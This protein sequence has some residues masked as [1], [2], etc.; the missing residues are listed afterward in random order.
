MFNHRLVFSSYLPEWTGVIHGLDVPFVFGALV[1]NITEPFTNILA[2]EY[3]EIE[4]GLSFYVLKLWTD[5]AKY[6]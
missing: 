1:K 6:G 3:S 4:K 2:T 5:F